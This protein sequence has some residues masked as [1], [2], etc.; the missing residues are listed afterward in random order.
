MPAGKTLRARLRA[1][2]VA[3]ALLA[4]P[5]AA[6]AERVV[7]KPAAGRVDAAAAQV[8]LYPAAAVLEDAAGTLTARDLVPPV[9]A[10]GAPERTAPVADQGGMAY[11]FVVVLHNPGE[12]PLQR[13]LVT[14]PPWLDDIQVLLLVPGQPAQVFHGGVQQP[15]TARAIVHRMPNVALALPPGES[16]LL[17]RVQTREPWWTIGN[18]SPYITALT[19][20]D[21]TAFYAADRG[22][23]LYFG[24][25]YGVLGALA[26][27]NLFLFFSTRDAVYGAYVFY[28][29][30]FLVMHTIY[31]GDLHALTWPQFPVWSK[32]FQSSA[33]AVYLLAG[34]YFAVSFL[35]LRS[36]LARA[37]RWAVTLGA[38]T[39][40]S[41]AATLAAGYSANMY[42]TMVWTVV[43]PPFIL[44]LGI[45]SLARGNRAA[46]FFLTAALA[47]FVGSFITA[48]TVTGILPY[49]VL[50]YRAL[51]L[52]MM[53]D[54][55]LLSLALADRLRLSRGEAE[56][57]RAQLLEATRQQARQLEAEVAVRTQELRDANAIKDK[58][59]SIVAHDLRGPIGG[60]AAYF[61]L[62]KSAREL[63]DEG[64][65]LVRGTLE[66]TRGFLEEL[67]TWAR[68]QRGEIECHPTVF[69]LGALLG[70]I[71]ELF[72]IRVHAD[73]IALQLAAGRDCWIRADLPMT[74]T[75][76]RNL[77]HN[78][79]KFTPRGGTV[80]AGVSR[81]PAGYRI[82]ITDT[83]VGMDEA[84]LGHVFQLSARID[85]LPAP[86]G[87]TGAGLGLILCKEF[88][89]KN[90]GTIGVSSTP[91]QGSTFWFTLPTAQAAEGHDAAEAI[92]RLRSL[93]L[94]VAEDDRLQ[95]EAAARLLRD[96]GCSTA[97]AA[98]G[99][100]ALQL[101][102]A[103]RFDLILMDIDM[104]R[105]DGIEATRRLRAAGYDGHIVSLSSYSR[106][107]MSALA[108]DL[109]F[110]AFLFKPLTRDDL[111]ALIDELFAAP[112]H[113][114]RSA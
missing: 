110:D 60:L 7:L 24:V 54:A 92:A 86:G 23:M 83:G 75:I 46:R 3:A 70:E 19:L 62:L 34:L 26:L 84:T 36:R 56:Q 88:V 111:L 18:P 25:I 107:E 80:R 4:L 11:W 106:Q 97:L 9:Y 98:D 10:S 71:Q 14:G 69:E 61:T 32:W 103:E 93:R 30:A 77:V 82:A 39:V 2:V 85:A 5:L 114:R 31:N 1:A 90:G 13:L 38:L 74:R 112:A 57:A 49:S 41:F 81:D 35:E 48:S 105:L 55:I 73:G 22:D 27:Y 102:T 79:L 40:V 96:L 109:W 59:F 100:E 113:E 64:L 52:G 76:L 58:F 50:N 43:H 91:G 104:P 21:E 47:G 28:L 37:Y 16:R 66:T 108:G 94:L 44:L 33:I 89:E 17:V 29:C 42:V 78:A 15:F 53:V 8:Q 72:S 45:W 99:E 95:R 68:S 67:L 65:A 20:W 101:G 12:T 63:T 51:D 6:A 87:E